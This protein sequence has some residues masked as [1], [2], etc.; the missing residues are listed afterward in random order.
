MSP[1]KVEDSL[2]GGFVWRGQSYHG[3]IYGWSSTI[4]QF[5]DP[6]KRALLLVTGA[7][8][9]LGAGIAMVYAKYGVK[10]CLVD[11]SKDV[12]KTA[13]K[14]RKQYNAHMT[15]T[16]VKWQCYRETGAHKAFLNC[17]DEGYSTNTAADASC[18]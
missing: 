10:L 18:T 4:A 7:A 12:E 8:M 11:M 3:Y 9:G 14:L 2:S 16:P 6:R 1:N 17:R 15:Q 13:D 5:V